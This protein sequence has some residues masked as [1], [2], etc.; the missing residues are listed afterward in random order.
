MNEKDKLKQA[1]MEYARGFQ[2]PALVW[3]KCTAVNWAE[4]TMDAMGITDDTEYYEVQL[5]AGAFDIKPSMGSECL[6]G[7]LEG[8][9]SDAILLC[10][11]KADEIAMKAGTLISLNNGDLGPLVVLQ[12]LKDS[13]ESLKTYCE[14]LKSA[15][16]QGLT[17]VGEST[18]ASGSAASVAFEAQMTATIEISD[19]ENKKITQ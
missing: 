1:L 15:V 13:L 5:G 19:L 2:V 6:V 3:V 16:S 17:A 11:T 8:N 12:P 4:R 9:P 14:A 10:A 18:S 7:I